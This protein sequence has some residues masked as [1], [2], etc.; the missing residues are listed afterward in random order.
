MV[1]KKNMKKLIMF[2]LLIILTTGIASADETIFLDSIKDNGGYINYG[3]EIAENKDGTFQLSIMV[4]ENMLGVDQGF[5]SSPNILANY[6][7]GGLKP[8]TYIE[9]EYFYIMYDRKYDS[10]EALGKEL[11]LISGFIFVKEDGK[12]GGIVDLSLW[13]EERSKDEVLNYVYSTNKYL[14]SYK[15][16]KKIDGNYTVKTDTHYVWALDTTIQNLIITKPVSNLKI[17]IPIVI[18][19]GILFLIGGFLILRRK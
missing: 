1:I 11:Y 4:K 17:I 16:L 6:E 7:A 18:I 3:I 15:P 10:F 8:K 2:I 13:N 12:L 9:G 14:F 19:G 5:F